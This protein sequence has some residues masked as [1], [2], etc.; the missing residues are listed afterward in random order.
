MDLEKVGKNAFRDSGLSEVA[1][2]PILKSIGETAFQGNSIKTVVLPDTV[3]SLG[4][5]A[6]ATNPKLE[7]IDLPNNLSEIPDSA[8]G[9]SDNKNWMTGLTSVDIPASVKKIGARAFAG[10][11]FTDIK[12]PK[13]VTELGDYAFATKNYLLKEAPICNLELPEGLTAIGKYAFRNKKVAEV[14]LPATVTALPKN[15]FA[16]EITSASGKTEKY[17]LL[18]RSEERRVGKECRSRWSPYH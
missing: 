8:F 7:K 1:F 5:G 12:V 6:F 16:K 13:G 15:V 17:D 2:S 3:T 10:N 14:K 18:T 4:R 9:C 11:N